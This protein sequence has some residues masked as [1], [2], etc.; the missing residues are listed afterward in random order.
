MLKKEL[1]TYQ[2][3]IKAL[4]LK[5]N[6]KNGKNKLQKKATEDFFASKKDNKDD[7][8]KIL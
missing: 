6:S 8:I 4:K 5:L 1:E 7:L 2:D 3:K